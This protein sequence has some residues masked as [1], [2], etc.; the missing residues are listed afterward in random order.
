MHEP[1]LCVYYYYSSS[2]CMLSLYSPM[3]LPTQLCLLVAP[4]LSLSLLHTHFTL[5]LSSISHCIFH[6]H[7]HDKMDILADFLQHETRHLTLLC[8]LCFFFG[9]EWTRFTGD[10]KRTWD[11]TRRLWGGWWWG[12][13]W[14]WWRTCVQAS[15]SLP[16]CHLTY[17]P[18]PFYTHTSC[19]LPS[20]PFSTFCSPT[21]T[22]CAAHT[23]HGCFPNPAPFCF[24]APSCDL[25]LPATALPLF[26]APAFP[27]PRFS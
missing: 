5:L 13:W 7:R 21:P 18:L 15:P 14:D 2:M 25:I 24:T 20:N 8:I 12:W 17:N 11:W 3:S 22:C 19:L 6:R 23:C 27:Y 4:K 16:A 1:F 9:K 26:P 10:M